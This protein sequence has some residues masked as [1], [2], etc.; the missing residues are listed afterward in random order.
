MKGGIAVRYTSCLAAISFTLTALGATL[1]GQEVAAPARADVLFPPDGPHVP[2]GLVPIV[3][4]D[5]NPYSPAKAELGWLLFFDKR[6]SSDG[7]VSCASCHAP[8]H[9]F[10]DGQPVSTGI[11]KQKGGRSAPSLINRAYG[12]AQYW[13]G[14][15]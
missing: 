14:R 2:L 6:L 11:G 1:V 3:W 7:T 12:A 8:E 5:D 13:H 9:G 15:A 4:P 10:G